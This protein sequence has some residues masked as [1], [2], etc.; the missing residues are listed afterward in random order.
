VTNK[1]WRF[2][3]LVFSA[4][5]VLSMRGLPTAGEP[6]P[7]RSA[8]RV[9]IIYVYRKADRALLL[10]GWDGNTKRWVGD[11]AFHRTV[12]DNV[13]YQLRSLTSQAGMADGGKPVL[14]EAS[15]SAYQI[16]LRN[17]SNRTSDTI[18]IPR[19][20]TPLPSAR[21]A[22]KLLNVDSSVYRAAVAEALKQHGMPGAKVNITRIV[23]V[24]LDGD[25]ADEVLIS[26]T[27]PHLAKDFGEASVNLQ[28]GD[29]SFVMLRK[30]KG[31]RVATSL[32]RGNFFPSPQKDVTANL[33]EIAGVLDLNGDGVMEV[34]VSSRY[35]EGGGASVFELKKGRLRKVLE[36][37]DGA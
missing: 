11:E 24:D 12:P 20:S 4:S 30:A 31:K 36:A 10:G 34:V 25:G 17:A 6:L 15:G 22:P 37:V 16:E 8:G 29:Y 2:G 33:Y 32:L 19:G 7:P 21:R 1:R 35:Y 5:L 18:G 27:S 13:K 26:A 28:K 9:P 23:Q 14:S 3:S